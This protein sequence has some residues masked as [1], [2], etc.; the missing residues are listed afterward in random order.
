MYDHIN[1]NNLALM[2]DCLF[3]NCHLLIGFNYLQKEIAYYN[4]NMSV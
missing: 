1:N 4:R 3:K 2:I